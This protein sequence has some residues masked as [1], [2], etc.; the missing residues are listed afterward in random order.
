MILI[1][2]VAGGFFMDRNKM[3]KKGY[4]TLISGAL[5]GLLLG[6]IY[7]FAPKIMGILILIAIVYCGVVFIRWALK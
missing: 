5:A 3:S 2:T 1:M 6:V 4:K 7:A